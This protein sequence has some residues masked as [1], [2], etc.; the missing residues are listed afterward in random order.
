MSQDELQ[1]FLNALA[2][3]HQIVYSAVSLPEPIFQADEL[4]K[5]GSN[6]Y[7]TMKQI[8]MHSVPRLPNK[9]VDAQVLTE[10]LSYMHSRL[11][12]TRFTA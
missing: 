8:D 1:A 11:Q 6:N 5:R 9:V 3:S 7:K 10:L 12:A 2:Y 4:A